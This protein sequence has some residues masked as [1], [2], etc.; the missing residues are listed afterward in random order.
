MST[1]IATSARLK[2]GEFLLKSTDAQSIFI[3][4]EWNEEQKMISQMCDDF[5]EKEVYPHLTELDA[6]TNPDLMPSIIRKAA[7]LGLL[8]AGLPEQYGGMGLDFLSQMLL[9]E[10]FGAG[11]SFAV[12]FSAHTGIGTLPTLYYGTEAQKD[13]YLPKLGSGEWLASYCLTEPGSG[14]DALGAKTVATL[15]EDGKH[16]II[17]GQKIWITNGG[18]ANLFTVFAK[19]DGKF[20]GFLVP[21]DTPGIS[22]SPEAHKMGIKGS[23]TREIFFQD[24]K[25]PVE[26]LLGEI[27]KGHKI[28]FNILNIGRIKLAAAAIGGGKKAIEV[29]VKYANERQQF[30]VAISTFGAIQHKLAEMAIRMW[31]MESAVYRAAY[32]IQEKEHELQAGGASYADALLGGAEE[33]AIECALLKVL[34]S[35]VVDYIVDEGVQIFGGNGFSADFPM[36]R[37]Y[38]DARIN[39]IFEGTNE[40]N[41]LLGIDM[42]MKRA[43]KGQLDLQTPIMKIMG[44]LTSIPE[45]SSDEDTSPLA[46]EAKAI[47]NMKK[48]ILMVSGAAVQTFMLKLEKEQEIIMNLADMGLYIY[49]AES[50]L[51]RAQKLIALRG[52]AAAADQIAM[53]KTYV[54]D[55]ADLVNK[56]GKDAIN[57]FAEGDMQRMMLMGLKRF[58]KVQPFN[59]KNARK[60][61][62][63]SLIE[64]NGYCY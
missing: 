14:S 30:G 49:A 32:D 40:I 45:F 51:L 53:V 60:Q 47:A 34:G 6:M 17:N 38:R 42:I 35:E 61:I 58:T 63:A 25:I 15:S 16:Y 43:M 57:S 22:R 13:A 46:A 8:G 55:A 48:A 23:S 50:G 54:Y 20:T 62:A 31:M 24:V 29:S 37:A 28:A 11:H 19:L 52:E 7:D 5:L 41:R 9:T 4:E 36:D 64:A 27:G 33:Y 59:G 56:A 1:A 21:G 12:G 18:F 39:R 26:N 2:G 44:E 10:R 3:P